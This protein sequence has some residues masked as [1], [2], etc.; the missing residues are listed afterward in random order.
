MRPLTITVSLLASV[1][2][3]SRNF[4]ALEFESSDCTGW[5]NHASIG[6]KSD[7]W[8]IK[9]QNE[10]NTIYT[11]TTND[12]I[13]RWYGFSGKAELGCDGEVLGRLPGGCLNLDQFGERVQCI[14]WCSTWMHDDHSCKA[15]GQD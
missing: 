15:I 2:G 8:Q 14:R 11:S 5:V 10:T 7:Y 1:C 6:F 4:L 13:Y 3:A 12:G 9:M